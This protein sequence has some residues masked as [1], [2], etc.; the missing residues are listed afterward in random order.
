MIVGNACRAGFRIQTAREWFA[1]SVHAAARTRVLV[2][3]EIE[4]SLDELT[5]EKLYEI[6][7]PAARDFIL[8]HVAQDQ[9]GSRDRWEKLRNRAAGLIRGGKNQEEVGKVMAAEFGWAAGS[10][11]MQ[12]SLPGI[13]TELK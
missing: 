6:D 5:A 2:R 1:Q 9:S 8:R 3:Y 4:W 7:A 12:W 11:Q 13:M 10:L